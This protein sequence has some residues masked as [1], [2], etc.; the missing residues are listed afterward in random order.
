[1]GGIKGT[2][3]LFEI[4]EKR[5]TSLF[6]IT[7]L[8]IRATKTA[9]FSSRRF[10]F[11]WRYCYPLFRTQESKSKRPSSMTLVQGATKSSTNFYLPSCRS[12]SSTTT[13]NS[14]LEPKIRSTGVAVHVRDQRQ[15][16]CISIN[17]KAVGIPFYSSYPDD[18]TRSILVVLP[19]TF[20]MRVNI[21]CIYS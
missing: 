12:Y 10:P 11:N 16:R 6:T 4:W 20:Y 1:M 13:S 14:E 5:E 17:C 15:K 8:P 18:F 9:A 2:F 7:E 21:V 3:P 19:D